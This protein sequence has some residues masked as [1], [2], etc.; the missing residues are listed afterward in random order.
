M[1]L[2]NYWCY[3]TTHFSNHSWCL[4]QVRVRL[5]CNGLKIDRFA[6]STDP[7]EWA[8]E[9][10]DY[11][12][13]NVYKYD[14]QGDGLHMCMI[15]KL[16]IMILDIELGDDYYNLNLPVVQQRLMA[17]GVRLAELLNTLYA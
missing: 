8:N 3:Q 12:V 1:G 5:F 4:Q 11:V 7:I 10:F 17:G 6:A 2:R 14:G 15:L 9:S 13:S 16:I